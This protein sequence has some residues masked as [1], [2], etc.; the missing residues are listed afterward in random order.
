MVL[1]GVGCLTT[2]TSR[3]MIVNFQIGQIMHP[4]VGEPL[5]PVYFKTEYGERRTIYVTSDN[6]A[7]IVDELAIIFMK[8]NTH[9]A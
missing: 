7:L 5:Y 2:T 9:E 8:Y 3:T 6:K 1:T 4:P